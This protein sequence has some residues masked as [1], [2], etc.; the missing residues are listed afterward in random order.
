MARPGPTYNGRAVNG[1]GTVHQGSCVGLQRMNR[2]NFL[3]V[4]GERCPRP[5][6]TSTTTGQGS[7]KSVEKS[8]GRHG[9]R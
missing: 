7:N 4:R 8:T 9:S 3:H 6:I 5:L 2:P 1:P